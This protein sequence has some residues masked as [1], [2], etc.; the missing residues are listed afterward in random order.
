MRKKIIHYIKTDVW[1]IRL[2]DLSG[3]KPL[4]LKHL[5][6]MILTIR[7]IIEDKCMLRA[8]ALTYYS[9]LSIGPVVALALGLAKWFGLEKLLKSQVLEKIPAQEAVLN[10]IMSYAHILLENTKGGVIAGIGVLVL[11]WAVLRV[12]HHIELA[13]NDI[14][15][16]KKS[17]S[18]KRKLINYLAF[19]VIAPILLMM[20]S[21]VPIFM[22]TQINLIAGK[23]IILQK[24]GP[25][26]SLF[27]KLFPYLT[28]WGLFT[29]IYILI[30]NTRVT[31]RAALQAGI[32]AGT[33]YLVVQWGLIQFQVG[34]SRYNPIYG[35]L[36]ALPMLLI[37]LHIGWVILLSGAEYSYAFQNVG[38]YEFEPDYRKISNHY[39]KLLTLQIAQLL[40]KRFSNGDTPLNAVQI[41][42][43][44][45][46][47]IRLVQ[48]I[49][50]ELADSGLVYRMK[51]DEYEQAVYQPA[52][53]INRWRIKYIT[54][55]LEKRGVD[56]M[57]V[58]QTQELKTLSQ[59][60]REI[61]EIIEKSPAN[62]LL[63]DI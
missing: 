26:I 12:L 50:D 46:I 22:A 63:K 23:I 55:K 38:L 48:Q 15:Q 62:N 49:L 58:A 7:G 20:Y 43:T 16:I 6:V 13:F 2:R 42:Q 17:R 30:P 40:V 9:L 19:V 51:P 31:F 32:I 18:W 44:L 39:N 28:I 5:R 60:L 56:D 24:I 61:D 45:E 54:D 27:L 34:V 11:F 52:S 25:L 33:I 29:F 41:S 36:A 57:P 47:P 10:Q 53:D 21:S 59:K 35:S 8:S 37:W 14:W 4:L 3:I 1:R